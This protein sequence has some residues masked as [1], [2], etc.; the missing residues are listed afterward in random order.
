M[1]VNKISFAQHPASGSDIYRLHLDNF[2]GVW[3][4]TSGNSTLRIKIKKVHY[5][6]KDW[7]YTEDILMGCYKYVKDGIVI[8]DDLSNFETIGQNKMSKIFVW[9]EMD[10]SEPTIVFGR[11]KD[12]L[13]HKT[14]TLKLQYVT[15][16]TPT[17]A[18]DILNIGSFIVKPT[19]PGITLLT[20]I[21]LVKL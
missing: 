15:G 4:W 9:S 3:E 8:E 12:H 6:F 16:V 5:Y 13:R 21:T 7:N 2:A 20:N 19:L 17:L 14:E 18:S 10:G 1:F 11:L